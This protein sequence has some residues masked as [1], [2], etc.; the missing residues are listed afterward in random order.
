MKTKCTCGNWLNSY[1]NYC[2]EC[3]KKIIESETIKE[4][5]CDHPNGFDGYD[6]TRQD[7]YCEI[8]GR[9]SKER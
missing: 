9:Y 7:S 8:C 3:G 2:P 5:P 4:A 1:Y 6:Y